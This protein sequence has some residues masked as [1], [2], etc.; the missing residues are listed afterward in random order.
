ML[1]FWHCLNLNG[2]QFDCEINTSLR[3]IVGVGCHSHHFQ[4]YCL[5]GMQHQ[6]WV[7]LLNQHLLSI[8]SAFIRIFQPKE[9]D[10][11]TV[12]PVAILVS[13][14]QETIKRGPWTLS[15]MNS[16]LWA[17]FSFSL[18]WEN[19]KSSVWS[20]RHDSALTNNLLLALDSFVGCCLITES[21]GVGVIA[22]KDAELIITESTSRKLS[23]LLPGRP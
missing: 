19:W 10:I 23:F 15:Q 14:I 13:L 12:D 9:S 20:S 3:L 16:P 2:P 4:S 1:V 21:K 11:R 18:K 22:R 6:H 5:S 7:Y 8:S 17:S